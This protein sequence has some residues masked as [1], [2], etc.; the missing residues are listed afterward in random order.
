MELPAR[1][2]RLTRSLTVVFI[3]ETFAAAATAASATTT[4]TPRGAALCLWASFIYF[5]I[6]SANF[7]SVEGCDGLGGFAVIGHFHEGKT[8]SPAGLT[9]GGQMDASD[10]AKWLKQSAQI[11]LGGLEAHIAN[12]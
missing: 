5:K 9:V 11:T 8:T 1:F 7:F 3:R 10:G 12:E 6:A 4:A 2:A